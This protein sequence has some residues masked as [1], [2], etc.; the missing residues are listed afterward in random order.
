[1]SEMR[2]WCEEGILATKGIA[3]IIPFQYMRL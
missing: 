3:E 2:C 1:M